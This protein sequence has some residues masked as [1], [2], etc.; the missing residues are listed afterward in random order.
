MTYHILIVDDDPLQRHTMEMLLNKIPGYFPSSAQSGQ[1]AL[2]ILLSDEGHSI[3]LVLLDM[4]MPEMDGMS[5]LRKLQK[6]QPSLPVII[7]TG[8]GDITL[9]VQALKEG[10][11]DFIEK[12]D[13]IERLKVS[14]ENVLR[15]NTLEHEVSRLQ[16]TVDGTI[17]LD[18]IIGNSTPINS[19]KEMSRRAA[20][21]N[22]PVL[23]RGESGVGKELFAR[24]IHG[25]SSRSGKAFIA[26]NC[27]AIP[28][29]LVES[30]LFG[31]E[32]GA[33]TGAIEKTIGKFREANGGTL[34]LDEVG[35]LTPDIQVKLLRAL[36][37]SEVE[38][39]GS[40]KTV[41]IDIRLISATN[42]DLQKDV[43]SGRFREDL[44]YRLNVFP[45]MVPPLRHRDGD[46]SLL[47]QHF[48]HRFSTQERK[49]NFHITPDAIDY[50]AKHSWPG[51][52]RQLENSIYRA[53]VLSDNEILDID[54]IC[55]LVITEPS[56][57]ESNINFS[58]AEA[59]THNPTLLI[60]DEQGQCRTLADIEADVIRMALD[61]CEWKLSEAARRLN[62]GRSTLYR[63]MNEYNLKDDNISYKENRTSASSNNA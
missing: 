29:N 9:A 33:F 7:H 34:F 58:K 17:T 41:K 4:S 35:E 18:D 55:Q 45:L 3:D 36:Q 59:A 43:E 52:I 53:V 56:T 63:K 8:H 26:V 28:E 49:K 22:I 19:T 25:E 62:I 1:E 32:K 24:A 50:L 27:G 38:P 13:T 39:V 14:I 40:S 31:H 30:V 60:V 47:A 20:S 2:E 54:D 48:C 16:R 44:Y 10:A 21:S 11:Q 12:K 42:R 15:I 51:N 37:E 57:S 6:N 23:I 5:V 46:I 61:V